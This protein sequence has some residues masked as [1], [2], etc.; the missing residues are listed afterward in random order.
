L[1]A[2]KL[3]YNYSKDNFEKIENLARVNNVSN[4]IVFLTALYITLFKYTQQEDIVVGSPSAN[5]IFAELKGMIGMF[6]N[7]LSLRAKN[8]SFTKNC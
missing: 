2:K 1:L 8:N 7:N 6:V 3:N 4:Y 5:R